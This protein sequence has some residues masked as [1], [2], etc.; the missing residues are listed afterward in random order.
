MEDPNLL[1]ELIAYHERGARAFRLD[2]NHARY[3]RPKEERSF[4]YDSRGTTPSVNSEDEDVDSHHRI[5]LSL[6]E[7]PKDLSQGFV[8]GSNP[9][10]CDVVIGH[11]DDGVSG[12]SFVITIDSQRRLVV[13]SAEFAIAVSYDGQAA[14]Q[15][16]SNFTWILFPGVKTIEIIV[17][18]QP[19]EVKIA[20]HAGSEI[21]YQELVEAYLRESKNAPVPFNHLNIDS[22][23]TTAA[24][25]EPESPKQLPVYYKDKILGQ[26]EFGTVHRAFDVSTGFVYACK[27]FFR[28][29]WQKEVEILRDLSH[30]HVVQFVL[31]TDEVKPSMI[32]EYL[33]LETLEVQ[34]EITRITVQESLDILYQSLSALQYLHSEGVAHRDIK[35]AN[36]LFQSRDP[37][38]IKLA[39]FGLATNASILKSRVGSYLYTAPEIWGGSNYTAAADIWSI[40]LVTFQYAYGLPKPK[41]R[42]FNAAS[43]Y[44]QIAEAVEDWDSEGLIEFLSSSM[45]RTET[46]DRKTAG[47]CLELVGALCKSSGRVPTHATEVTTPTE[48]M[49]SSL[50]MEARRHLGLPRDCSNVD[51]ARTQIG[52]LMVSDKVSNDPEVCSES[53]RSS[54]IGS[55]AAEA[56]EQQQTAIAHISPT[57]EQKSLKR[58]LSK[59]FGPAVET[60]NVPRRV[61]GNQPTSAVLAELQSRYIQITLPETPVSMRKR[62]GW[63]NAVQILALAGL[64]AHRRRQIFSVMKGHTQIEDDSNGMSWVCY[65]HGY[66]LSRALDLQYKL[67]PL[68]LYHRQ[69]LSFDAN[70]LYEANYL[71]GYIPVNAGKGSV[72]IRRLDFRVNATHILKEAGLHRQ[73]AKL[74]RKTDVNFDIVSGAPKYQGSYVNFLD[75][76]QLCERYRLNQLRDLLV[77]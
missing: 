43:W 36:I 41:G 8:F 74:L 17:S 26:G 31:F 40:G 75:A 3:L 29:P 1:L 20:N 10:V 76:L 42:T 39:D 30:D 38:C 18:R 55:R 70:R 2:H 13:R 68:L 45:L 24:P 49:S 71:I 12:R 19:F 54:V 5:Q 73:T 50:I 28:G 77:E 57:T 63:L 47:E 60:S 64:D 9:K 62:D 4:Q 11:R 58:R 7:M 16:R 48:A 44:K 22:Q 51:A 6:D 33:A 56:I 35:P 69:D 53:R 46:H 15:K 37:I 23:N 52:P 61:S 21:K 27:E 67:R 65:E 25:T 34:H 32:M 59:D 14:T 72:M 66:F